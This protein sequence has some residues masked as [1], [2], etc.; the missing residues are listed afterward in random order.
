MR[1]VVCNKL[2]QRPHADTPNGRNW[3][4]EGSSVL[5]RCCWVA[6]CQNLNTDLTFSTRLYTTDKPRAPDWLCHRNTCN[7]SSTSEIRTTSYLQTTDRKYA[8]K[9]QVAVQNSFQ[10]WT[11][12]EASVHILE[13]LLCIYGRFHCNHVC[14]PY[15]PWPPSII[16]W[17]SFH[18][19]ESS[20][21]PPQYSL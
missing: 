19:H 11:E 10:E 4:N 6:I 1:G 15:D 14:L 12:I 9:G 18:D 21:I 20:N 13:S 16:S 17:L 2:N 7:A 3:Q 5:C 8:P